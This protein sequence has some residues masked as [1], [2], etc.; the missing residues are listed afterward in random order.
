I[1]WNRGLLVP[2][3]SHTSTAK[4]RLV[5]SAMATKSARWRSP[6]QRSAVKAAQVKN[7]AHTRRTPK[8]VGEKL[9]SAATSAPENNKPTA[10][11]NSKMPRRSATEA[12]TLPYL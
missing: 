4:N 11:E 6:T 1:Q 5:E 8:A 3:V 9:P 7:P 10:A 2:P 12:F